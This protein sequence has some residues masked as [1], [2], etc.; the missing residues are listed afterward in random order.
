MRRRCRCFNAGAT[1]W[2]RRLCL[3]YDEGDRFLGLNLIVKNPVEREGDDFERMVLKTFESIVVNPM[4]IVVNWYHGKRRVSGCSPLWI[5]MDTQR[6]KGRFWKTVIGFE[7][8]IPLSA[9]PATSD[10]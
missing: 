1:I 2:G 3:V 7:N 9:V 5:I 4:L 10:W 8:F 6:R